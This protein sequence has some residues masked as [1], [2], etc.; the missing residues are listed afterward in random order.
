MRNTTRRSCHAQRGA[1]ALVVVMLL[2]FIISLV[3]AYASRNLIFEQRTSA[4]NYR[5]T[6]AFDAAEAGLE[7][8]VA[9]LNGG[10]IDT[11][12]AG[13]ADPASNSFRDRYLRVVD[14][15]GRLDVR[16]WVNGGVEAPLLPSC[17]RDD[18]GWSCSCPVSGNP[19]LAAPAGTTVAPAFRVE[20]NAVAG[21]PHVVRIFVRGCSNW[22]TPCIDGAT[23]RAEANAEINALVGLAPALTQTPV[24]AVTVRGPLD[25]PVA[26]FVNPDRTGLAVNA[27]GSAPVSFVV[28]P[29]GMPASQAMSALVVD[30]D[31]SLSS[32]PLAGALTERE[33]MFLA[34][35]GMPPAAFRVQA[36]VRRIVCA[37]DCA[38]ALQD[39][40]ERF[41]GR[42]LWIDGDLRLA[43]GTVL[44][45]GSATEPVLLVV[46]GN[47][48]WAAGANVVLRGVLWVRGT[49]WSSAG[50]AATVI[51]ALVAEG[52]AAIGPP[53][54]GRF[55][56]AGNP[57]F[58]FDAATI[59]HL[60]KVQAR[61]VFDFA[62]F[63]RLP[64]SWRDFR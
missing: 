22:G 45:L 14:D 33:M 50:A 4:N 31:P 29:P 38:A 54:E 12:C 62:S 20:F 27:G 37:D 28:G 59:D 10:R 56:I 24:A 57:R 13:S 16:R 44:S 6:Q 41:P 15:A 35:F 17:V 43:G 53:D 48:D 64:G 23:N 25:A 7:W 36:A 51:G 52:D 5:A 47:V 34:G 21:Q 49:S 19:V 46:D 32:I 61:S 40:A 11:A 39:A 42:V 8:A 2:F 63:T 1:A 26:E 3:A 58:V 60:K 55:T 18:G 9:M 30:N